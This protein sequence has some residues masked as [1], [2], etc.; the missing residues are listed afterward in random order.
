V[1]VIAGVPD[2]LWRPVPG[3]TVEIERYGERYSTFQVQ[4]FRMAA[5]PVTFAQFRAFLD[6]KDGYANKRWW[7]DL[8]HEDRD[9]AWESKLWNHPVTNVSW[10]DATAFCRWLSAQLDLGVRL[11]D[12]QEWQQAAQSAKGYAYP[13]GPEWLDGRANTDESDLKH[14]TAVGM[15][16]HG[17]SLQKV[18]D[19]SGNVF[20]WCRNEDEELDRAKPGG[21]QSRVLRGGPG[22]TIR[23]SRARTAAAATVRSSGT[24]TSVFA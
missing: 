17:D 22:T 5:F 1:G 21:E 11:P 2:I 24:T 6:A 10:F 7:E 16:P 18:S 8:K 20:D 13:W 4:P 23:T 14:L 15:F 9:P 19:L 12:D 3:G